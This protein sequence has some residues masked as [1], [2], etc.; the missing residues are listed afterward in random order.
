MLH[1]YIIANF[2][3]VSSPRF[4]MRRH[5]FLC[6]MNVV[7]EHDNYFVQKRNA[8]GM[9]GLSCLQKVIEAFRVLAYGVPADALDE[10]IRIGESTTLEALRKFVVDVVE[11]FGPEYMRLPT[12]HDTARLLAIGA[13]RGFP[14]MLGS[15]D[16]MHWSWK[17]CPT[18]WHGMYRGHK[19][20]STI[21]LE[22][23]ASKDLWI[24]HALF[25]MPGSH[26]DINVLQ[27]SPLFTRL[28]EGEGP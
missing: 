19:K 11:V 20:E 25:G 6:T 22:A 4:R 8:T 7:E 18:T 15:I 2:I 14:G 12:E 3:T 13:S 5:V 9:L 26:N 16:C 24:W 1:H 28:A 10:Y 23:V 17:N 27:R 21:I